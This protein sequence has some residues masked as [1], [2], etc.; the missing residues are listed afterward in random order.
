LHTVM[1]RGDPLPQGNRV[2]VAAETRTSVAVSYDSGRERSAA[3]RTLK[4][5]RFQVVPGTV[6]PA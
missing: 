2:A 5:R 3:W 4:G 1:F 6:D